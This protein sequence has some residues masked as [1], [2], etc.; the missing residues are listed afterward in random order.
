M[1]GKKNLFLEKRVN[2]ENNKNIISSNKCF[3]IYLNDYIY[4]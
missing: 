3:H 4:Y 1:S 2:Y